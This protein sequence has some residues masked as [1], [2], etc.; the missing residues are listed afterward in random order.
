MFRG[1]P[2][3]RWSFR[4]FE[5]WIRVFF[6]VNCAD[7]DALYLKK[8]YKLFHFRPDFLV[9][10]AEK[11]QKLEDAPGQSQAAPQWLRYQH[12]NEV[13]IMSFDQ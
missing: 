1:V 8:T 3:L 5:L 4:A 11:G 2:D 7:D 9:T 6:G 10:V 13:E 12:S